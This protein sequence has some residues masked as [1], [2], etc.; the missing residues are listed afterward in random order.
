VF[1]VANEQGA[2][3]ADDAFIAGQLAAASRI[4]EPLGIELVAQPGDP[5]G[6]AHARLTSRADRDALGRY[7]RRGAIHCMVVASLLDVD[8]PG[9]VRRGVHWT[10]RDEP[11]KHFVIVSAIA[12][13]YV[14][15][16]ELGH[17]F[18][19]RT[20]SDTPGNLMSYALGEGE[21]FLDDAQKRRVARTLD[22]LLERGEL[23]PLGAERSLT[24]P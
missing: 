8:E 24:D 5:L 6:A 18:G 22:A 19:N 16:H 23:R 14:L 13:E 11:A 7:A 3:V 17:Y 4:F 21:P 12:S 9:R 15:A 1:H 20:H 2:R 10:V